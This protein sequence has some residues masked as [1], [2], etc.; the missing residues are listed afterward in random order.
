M[1][2][3]RMISGVV[4]AALIAVIILA[5]INTRTNKAESA[6]L[7]SSLLCVAP[8]AIGAGA[9][10]FATLYGSYALVRWGNAALGEREAQTQS[11][12]AEAERLRALADAERAKAQAG[13]EFKVTREGRS[14]PMLVNGVLLNPSLA[15]SPATLADGNTAAVPADDAP[16]LRALATMAQGQGGRVTSSDGSQLLL[17][18]SQ[19]PMEER[20]PHTVRV[21]DEEETRLL[22]PSKR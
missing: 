21:M 9:F 13:I 10:S 18:A 17:A 8:I 16:M 3:K 1:K 19:R 4:A 15:T 5:V 22:P 11:R 12:Q 7:T 6:P 2:E 20:V 14:V